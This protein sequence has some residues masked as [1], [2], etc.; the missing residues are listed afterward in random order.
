V[1]GRP[2]PG[3]APLGGSSETARK[4]AAEDETERLVQIITD[5]I[6]ETIA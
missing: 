6:I 5:R 3:A 1:A 4:R 2:I